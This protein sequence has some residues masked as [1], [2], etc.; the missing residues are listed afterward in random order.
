MPL[1]EPVWGA[2]EVVVVVVLGR[3]YGH[4]HDPRLLSLEA[5]INENSLESSTRQ[6]R[7]MTETKSSQVY[8]M[9][10]YTIEAKW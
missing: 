5:S 4:D 8:L 2:Q 10:S 9:Q 6:H 3:V 7:V 1:L